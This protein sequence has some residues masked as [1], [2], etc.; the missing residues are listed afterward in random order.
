MAP[1]KISKFRSAIKGIIYIVTHESL[2]FFASW[3]VTG[4]PT[5]SVTIT[6]IAASAEAIYYYFY[7]RLWIKI[8]FEKRKKTSA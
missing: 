7:E 4:S 3:L 8:D 6:V 5:Q 2:L 1:K